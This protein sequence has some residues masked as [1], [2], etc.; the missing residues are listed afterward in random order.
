MRTRIVFGL[1]VGCCLAAACSRSDKHADA[2]PPL[3]ASRVL[4]PEEQQRAAISG[5]GD[6]RT[7]PPVDLPPAAG[8][9]KARR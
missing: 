8:V 3:D 4:T 9:A 1:L 6:A 5:I 2:R 7:L